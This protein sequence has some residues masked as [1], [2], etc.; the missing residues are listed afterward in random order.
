MSLFASIKKITSK[1]ITL[2]KYQEKGGEETAFI[3]A[4]RAKKRDV[5]VLEPGS[6]KQ[7]PRFSLSHPHPSILLL[8]L[9]I[10]S[11]FLQL[12]LSPYQ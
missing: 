9:I 4:K 11:H 8:P 1:Q 3:K 2:I 10:F 7:R 6:R 12:S 5:E